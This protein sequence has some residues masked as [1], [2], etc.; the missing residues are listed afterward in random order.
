M[1]IMSRTI[2]ITG[3]SVL[4]NLSP[5]IEDETVMAGVITPSARRAAP[6][7]I[8]RMAAHEALSFTSAI[9]ANIPPSPLLSALKAISTYLIVAE[10]VSVQNMQDNPP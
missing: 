1:P 10:R 9:S 7:T 2:G 3:V 6:P 4:N 5:S 8:V